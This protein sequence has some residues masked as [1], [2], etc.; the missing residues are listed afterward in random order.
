[1]GEVGIA[2]LIADVLNHDIANL[3]IPLP[4]NICHQRFGGSGAAVRLL[5][6]LG[7]WW[8]EEREDDEGQR[9]ARLDQ[10]GIPAT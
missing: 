4:V 2:P 7:G 6:K 9:D 8:Q 1:M 5:C 3:A 10:V